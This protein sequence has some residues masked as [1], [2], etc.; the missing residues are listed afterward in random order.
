LIDGLGKLGNGTKSWGPE[1]E[2]GTAKP[3][4]MGTASAN[5]NQKGAVKGCMRSYHRAASRHP[6]DIFYINAFN[7][8]WDVGHR[9]KSVKG[10]VIAVS[11]PV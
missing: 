11:R 5:L 10:A 9:L 3:A 7:S 8:G 2:T 4:P 1:D 6:A